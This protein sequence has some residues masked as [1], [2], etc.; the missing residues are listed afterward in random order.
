MLPFRPLS[1]DSGNY[2]QTNLSDS[3]SQL[4]HPQ[5]WLNIHSTCS[6]TF[7]EVH[8]SIHLSWAGYPL[9]THFIIYKMSLSFSMAHKGTYSYP[10]TPF[11]SQLKNQTVQHPIVQLFQ[12]YPSVVSGF[13]FY[14]FFHHI[15]TYLMGNWFSASWEN[16]LTTT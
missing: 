2:F 8:S 4:W 6:W 9:Y 12:I 14:C 1:L 3:A 10:F 11:F 15:S 5:I 7:L 16:S 13:Y